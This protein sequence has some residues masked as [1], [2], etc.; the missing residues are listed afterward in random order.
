MACSMARARPSAQAAEK[1]SSPRAWRAA[2]GTLD[3]CYCNPCRVC[4]VA[5]PGPVARRLGRGVGPPEREH[6]AEVCLQ[7][8]EARAAR[9]VERGERGGAEA[10]LRDQRTPATTSG[11]NGLE[12]PALGDDSATRHRR[13]VCFKAKLRSHSPTF[14]IGQSTHQPLDSGTRWTSPCA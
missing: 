10:Y 7:A 8:L 1:A 6:R 12:R 5:L 4:R 13:Q 2:V 11:Y 14:I 9:A 3:R